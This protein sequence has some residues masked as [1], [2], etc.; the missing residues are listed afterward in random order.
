MRINVGINVETKDQPDSHIVPASAP[1]PAP[2]DL[3]KYVQRFHDFLTH[4]GLQHK[5]Y[6]TEGIQFCLRNEMRRG[7]GLLWTNHVSSVESSQTKW[8]SARLS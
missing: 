8:D 7:A 2:L 1:A 3:S 4:A 5:D 6:Q